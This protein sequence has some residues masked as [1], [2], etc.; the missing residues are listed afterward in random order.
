MHSGRG[1]AS[2]RGG[3]GGQVPW[4]RSE[5][6]WPGP[7]VFALRHCFFSPR[8]LARPT[9]NSADWPQPSGCTC[10]ILLKP[11]TLACCRNEAIRQALGAPPTL[12]GCCH[13][14]MAHLGHISQ[15]PRKGN[16]TLCLLTVQGYL[17]QMKELC[18]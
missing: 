4:K 10:G 17:I 7:Q 16:T 2:C 6:D 18:K 15:H 12:A 5:Q 11:P 13:L 9:G 3:L 1:P 8:R 14:Q